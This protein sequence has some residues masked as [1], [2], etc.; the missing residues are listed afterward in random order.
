M[1][2]E[3]RGRREPLLADVADVRLFPRVRPH[4]AFQKTRTIETLAAD[5][6]GQHRLPTPRP[7]IE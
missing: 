5:A 7:G 4:V 2:V 6:T 1:S 3:A